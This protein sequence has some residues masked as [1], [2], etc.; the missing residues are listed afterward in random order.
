MTNAE[1][2]CEECYNFLQCHIF[3]T[4]Y[5]V[6]DKFDTTVFSWYDNGIILKPQFNFMMF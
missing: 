5:L 6:I 1:L 4:S 2:L 3:V